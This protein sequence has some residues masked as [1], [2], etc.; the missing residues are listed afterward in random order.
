MK[1]LKE[2]SKA[3]F[4]LAKNLKNKENNICVARLYYSAF[5]ESCAL[6]N[7]CFE[8]ER[9]RNLASNPFLKKVGFILSSSN[10]HDGSHDKKIKALK[11][12][13]GKK[14]GHE[15]S[16]KYESKMASLQEIRETADYKNRHVENEEVQ[17]A[18]LAYDEIKTIFSKL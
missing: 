9:K 3:N 2:K 17:N 18:F 6:L 8:E 12:F 1:I 5:Q 13:I 16:S 11:L 15:L 10:K 7:S 4:E 14:I